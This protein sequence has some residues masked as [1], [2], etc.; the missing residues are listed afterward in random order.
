MADQGGDIVVDHCT[1]Y[2]R[3]FDEVADVQNRKGGTLMRRHHTAQSRTS[4]RC[5]RRPHCCTRM[6]PS[7]MWVS[8]CRSR[9]GGTLVRPRSCV[10]CGRAASLFVLRTAAPRSSG[11]PGQNGCHP[12]V[13]WRRLLPYCLRTRRWQLDRFRTRMLSNLVMVS[14][15]RSRT[16]GT[17]K[18]PG[19]AVHAGARL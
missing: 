6:F 12:M 2:P 13:V 19:P 5:C 11:A 17:L 9:T 7:L 14:T 8:T 18:F 4:T 3:G 16:G 1:V 15:S 10:A